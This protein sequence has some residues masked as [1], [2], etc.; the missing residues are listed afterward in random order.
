MSAQPLYRRLVNLRDDASGAGRSPSTPPLPKPTP[1]F[2]RRHPFYTAFGLLAALS[3]FSTF[4]PISAAVTLGLVAV[5]V[6]GLDARALRAATAL[7]RRL[8]RF[9]RHEAPPPPAARGPEPAPRAPVK[10]G[11]QL[12]VGERTRALPGAA[13]TEH[14]VRRREPVAAARRGRDSVGL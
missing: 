7:G 2:A 14:S 6:T 12:R 11:P 1:S 5:R 10:T 4:W 3:L 8:W 9:V 13:R